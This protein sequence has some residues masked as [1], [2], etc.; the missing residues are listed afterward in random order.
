MLFGIPNLNMMSC[1]NSTALAKVKDAMGLYSIHLVN[2]QW[3]PTL[4][5]S[6]LELS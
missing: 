5:Y 3:Q 1:M 4:E 2:F 6:L